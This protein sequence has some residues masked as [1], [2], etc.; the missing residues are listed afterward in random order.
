MKYT[1]VTSL[2]YP[3]LTTVSFVKEQIICSASATNLSFFASHI[4]FKGREYFYIIYCIVHTY[5]GLLAFAF[6][7]RSCTSPSASRLTLRV[8]ERKAKAKNLAK[9]SLPI[10]RGCVRFL[11]LCVVY[12]RCWFVKMMHRLVRRGPRL[13]CGCFCDGVKRLSSRRMSRLSRTTFVS[14]HNTSVM[15]E[16]AVQE[17]LDV[18]S[19]KWTRTADH[20]RVEECPFCRKPTNGKRDNLYK[21][22]IR[23]DGVYFCH[24]CGSKG[25]WYDFKANLRGFHVGGAMSSGASSSGPAGQSRHG[26]A[27]PRPHQHQST[28]GLGR[29]I[30]QSEPGKLPDQR[31]NSVAVSRL[32]SEDGASARAYLNSQR[33]L[34][35]TTLKKYGVGSLVYKFRNSEGKYAR[36]ECVTFPWM[37][38]ADQRKVM[39]ALKGAEVDGGED[40]IC[41]R[42]KARSLTDKSNMRLDPT[43]G[44]WGLFGWH[45]VQPTS[46]SLVLTEGEYD[47][48][49][50]WQAT[51]FEAV[52]LPNGC[53]SFPLA[54]LPML[55]KFDKI[56]LWMDNDA[57]GREGAEVAA[58]KFGV[59]RCRIVDGSRGR[60]KGYQGESPKDANDA[61]LKGWNLEE[62]IV[63]AKPLGHNNIETFQ[64]FRDDVIRELVNPYEYAGVKIKS[65]P[66]VTKILKG[67]RRG[68]MTVLTGPTGSGKVS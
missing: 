15:S 59:E 48:M 51:G 39:E 50:V 40:W 28:D 32:H 20:F 54:L 10:L 2:F 6:S 41:N 52:S 23:K 18:N 58:K 7:M 67:F 47:A 9:N 19:M 63:S 14:S 38:T 33:G 45:T 5:N 8:G 66:G 34:N 42:I 62:M 13:G 31:Q 3:K 26:P 55:E 24:R 30:S 12:S 22:Y 11:A 61:M 29:S 44:G 46:N 49:A 35:D 36:E 1:N 53:R 68:E 21:L 25:S 64:D 4:C 57:P 16:G 37:V 27:E 43:G 17:Y 65:L 60:P 56:Y